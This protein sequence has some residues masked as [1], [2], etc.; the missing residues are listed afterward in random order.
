MPGFFDSSFW[1]FELL[2]ASHTLP[3]IRHAIIAIAAMHRKFIEGRMPVVPED[4]SSDRQLQ[5][6]LQ[7]SNRAIQELRKSSSRRELTLSDS[8]DTMTACILFY[9][10]SCF[11]GHQSEAL[12]HLRSGLKMLHHVDAHLAARR[13]DI[14]HHPISLDTLRTMFV[15]MDIQARGIMADE[16]LSKW[17]PQ[18]RRNFI[19]PTS[20]KTFA[21]ARYY[22]EAIY[23]DLLAFMQGLDIN[24]PTS[25]DAIQAV[26]DQYQRY[27][28]EFDEMST[29]LD[30]FLARLSHVTNQED[31]ESILGIRLFREQVKVF[32]RVYKGF[33]GNKHVREIDWHVDENSMA[34][35]LDLASELLKAPADLSI[36]AG[37]VPEDYYPCPADLEHVSNLA[38]PAYSRPVFSSNS[39]MLS[40]LWLVCAR[41][42]SPALRRR[43]IALMLDYPRREGVWDGV[44]A[45]R[46]AWESLILEETALEGEL[47]ARRGRL[48]PR[49]EYIP[50]SN[51]VRA[52][53]I[54][55][56]D[57]RAMRVEFRS[58][59]QYEAGQRG[60]TRLIA[61]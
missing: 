32:L 35:I 53:E 50:E 12:H 43:A 31:R 46:I 20:F 13:E 60:V 10:I 3:A 6:A 42:K 45:G 58:V 24:P 25:P 37:A 30:M 44:V 29:C 40:G 56:V 19:L 28:R 34:V 47:G 26:L 7:Q 41:A 33:D 14:S 1:Q 57:Q 54:T 18:P 16:E 48:E 38:I 55:Y 49:S 17:E 4:T 36:P 9:C 23:N 52:V 5:F 22:F 11:Q 8:I 59:K 15:T 2:Q 51:K 27:Q 61:W 39:G 21:Q